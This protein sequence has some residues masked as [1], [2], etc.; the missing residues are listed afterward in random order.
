MTTPTLPDDNPAVKALIELQAKQDPSEPYNLQADAR[1]LHF[2]ATIKQI[3]LEAEIDTT[4]D[5]P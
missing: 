2:V 3:L 1:F 5:T 4:E